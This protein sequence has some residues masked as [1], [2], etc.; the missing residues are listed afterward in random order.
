MKSAN[1]WKKWRKVEKSGEKLAKI[2]EEWRKVANSWKKWRKVEKSG[3][4]W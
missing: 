1:S 2:G 4:K 3:E